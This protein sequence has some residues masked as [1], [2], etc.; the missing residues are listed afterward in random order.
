MKGENKDVD[1]SKQDSITNQEL[2]GSVSNRRG[3]ISRAAGAV[4]A[5]ATLPGLSVASDKTTKQS[6][7]EKQELVDLARRYNSVGAVESTLQKHASEILKTLHKEGYIETPSVSALSLSEPTATHELN[8]SDGVAVAGAIQNETPTTWIEVRQFVGDNRISLVVLPQLDRSYAIIHSVST[9]DTLGT[10]SSD[11]TFS[12]Q[13]DDVS[14][15]V[16]LHECCEYRMS[17]DGYEYCEKMNIECWG[18]TTDEGCQKSSSGSNCCIYCSSCT[19]DCC[20]EK[21]GYH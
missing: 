11:G 8:S 6:P 12:T 13:S 7:K 2:L 20:L 5:A 10:V 16:E 19:D 17:S 21:C 1:D 9:N 15:M 3:F 14:P 4:S 18:K